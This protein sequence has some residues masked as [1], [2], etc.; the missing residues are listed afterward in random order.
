MKISDKRTWDKVIYGLIYPG[1][2]GSMLYELI[3]TDA[4]LF[5]F[6]FFFKTAENYIRYGIL[7]FYILDYI[8]LSTLTNLE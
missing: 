6:S 8:H 7:I 5:T 4:T 2:L 1:F 3:P